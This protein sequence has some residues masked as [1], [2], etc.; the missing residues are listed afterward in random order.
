MNAALLKAGTRSRLVVYPGL[1]H[2]L[3][4]SVARTDLLKQ[5][6]AFFRANLKIATP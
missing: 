6:D 4:D 1:D 5:A 3:D 2:Q